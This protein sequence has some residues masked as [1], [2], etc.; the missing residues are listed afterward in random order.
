M[1]NIQKDEKKEVLMDNVRLQKR[2]YENEEIEVLIGKRTY[3][4]VEF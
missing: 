2:L 3:N 1:F 4:V